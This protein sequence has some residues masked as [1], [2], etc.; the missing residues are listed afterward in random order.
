MTGRRAGHL[1]RNLLNE[2]TGSG[3]GHDGG[4]AKKKRVTRLIA[5]PPC[6]AG[7]QPASSAAAASTKTWHPSTRSWSL[8]SSA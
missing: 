3:A 2:M 7:A 4:H 8:V 5:G 1:A 6:A